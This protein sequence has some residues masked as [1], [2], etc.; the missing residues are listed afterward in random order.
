MFYGAKD[1]ESRADRLVDLAGFKGSRARVIPSLH[2]SSL[3]RVSSAGSLARDSSSLFGELRDPR[4]TCTKRGGMRVKEGPRGRREDKK[5]YIYIY[6]YMLRKRRKKWRWCERY[7][8]RTN[9]IYSA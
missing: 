3:R 2:D 1:E 6:K 4:G 9:D 7:I 8:A 5:I